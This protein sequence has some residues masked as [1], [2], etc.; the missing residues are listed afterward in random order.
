MPVQH[1]DL[2]QHDHARAAS[3]PRPTRT[4]LI[5]Q[6]L[7][8]ASLHT[9]EQ[10]C[11]SRKYRSGILAVKNLQVA[12]FL[13]TTPNGLEHTCW[14]VWRWWQMKSNP[15]GRAE[16]WYIAQ[17]TVHSAW[18]VQSLDWLYS[19]GWISLA[20]ALFGCGNA[21]VQQISST[22]LKQ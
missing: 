19:R 12:T 15:M 20:T 13:H 16:P 3:W 8:N 6:S 7:H 17:S 11:A 18:V 14:L 21:D 2:D 10:Q 5:A 9:R 4:T 1:P 22:R